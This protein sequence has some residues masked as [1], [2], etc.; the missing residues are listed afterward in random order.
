MVLMA[1]GWARAGVLGLAALLL[2]SVSQAQQP[3]P[4][5]R[6]QAKAAP[7]AARDVPPGADAALQ[8]RVEQ[9]EEQLVDL[10]VVIGTLESLA[11]GG[12]A[13]AAGPRG[14]PGLSAAVNAADAGRLDA[15]ETQ[16]RALA[17]QL[18]SLQDQVRSLGG[19]TGMAVPN[20]ASPPPGFGSVTVAPDGQQDEVER[21]PP[22]GGPPPRVGF[23]PPGPQGEPEVQPQQLYE[24]AYGALLQKDYATAEAG[25]D[26]F[27]RRH[28]NHQ[29]A[30][31]AQYWLGETFYVRGQFRAAA[32]AFLKGYQTYS[33][34][35]K[36]PESLLKLA[37]SLSRL[38][39]KDAACSSYNELAT[40]YPNPPAHVKS[41]AQAER[42]RSGCGA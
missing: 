19:R 28:S 1:T 36:A 23:A 26:D 35:P 37:M 2:A 4:P 40:K 27:L 21:M 16:I 29:L 22:R 41:M 13:P 31:N 30:G 18:E 8:R 32:A 14:G 24:Q 15:I 12:G 11:K 10:Q 17:A 38:G 42:Q 20:S 25:F 7:P 5:P 6:P 33:R 34:S 39:Q 3:P 9:L